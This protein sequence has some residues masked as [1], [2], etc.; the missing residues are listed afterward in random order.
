MSDPSRSKSLDE[1]A[2]EL[3]E[4]LLA[5]ARSNYCATVIQHWIHP[6]NP[7]PMEEADGHGRITG[8][9]G[10]TMEIFVKIIDGVI[11]DASFTTDGCGTSIATASMA[12]ELAI[13]CPL[14]SAT[15]LTDQDILSALGGLPEDSQHCAL[16]A[17]NTLHAAIEPLLAGGAHPSQLPRG[18]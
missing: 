17:A 2:A 15:E 9:C 3:Q 18:S 5:E 14:Q 1:L 10:D 8:P 12:V 7:H 13:G 6:R 4:Q 11:A 16:L